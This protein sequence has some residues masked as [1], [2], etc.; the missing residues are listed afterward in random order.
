MNKI[1]KYFLSENNVPFQDYFN[2]GLSVDCVV[3]GYVGEE[4]KVL[5]VQRDAEPFLGSW[6]LP[7]DLV[8]L[9]EDLADSASNVLQRLTGLEDIF[10]EQ[11]YAFGS[12][13]RH[14][15]GRVATVGYYSLVKSDNYHPVASSWVK[16]TKWFSIKD[17][18][19]LAFD[20]NQ[21]LEKAINTLK[22]RVKYRPVGFELLPI[23]F[24]LLELQALYEALLDYKF[25]KPNFRK[26][27]LSMDL[28]VQLDEV[29]ANVSHRPA[30]LFQFDETRYIELRKEGFAF[31]ITVK[32]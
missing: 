20:H 32:G 16:E 28:L 17:L 1:N 18:P 9:D 25:D 29:Q 26:K 23:K 21:V 2:F 30:K 7:G 10:M 22:R 15:A 4:I 14:P 31:D 3:F 19:K 13:D 5:L 27:I 24:T 6:A 11:F 8:P 12:V